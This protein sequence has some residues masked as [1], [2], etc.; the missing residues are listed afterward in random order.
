M[1]NQIIDKLYWEFLIITIKE[2]FEHLNITAI[3][4]VSIIS[5][6]TGYGVH[7]LKNMIMSKRYIENEREKI[8]L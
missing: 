5:S 7:K 1:N 6:K 3:E 2:I 8:S 4:N